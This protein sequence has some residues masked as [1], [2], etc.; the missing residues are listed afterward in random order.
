LK[1]DMT[2]T[3]PTTRCLLLEE[4]NGWLTIWFNQ[5]DS[6]NALSHDLTDELRQV[7][8]IVRASPTC[9]GITL[10]GKGGVFC[11]GG[12]LK[13]FKTNFQGGEQGRKDVVQAS[14]EAGELFD[15][16]NEMPQVVV[17]LVEGAAMAGGLGIVCC[18]D[19]VAVTADARF[20]LTETT[21]G[22]PPAQIAPFV[23][24]RLGLATA[25]RLMLT[26]ARFKGVEAQALGLADFVADDVA[27]LNAIEQDIRSNVM[28]CAP[29][30]N[31]VTKNIVLATEYLER[32]EMLQ[33]A[34]EGFADC[35]LGEEGREGIT[36]FV[37]K[38]KPEWAPE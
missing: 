32:E 35:M 22:I 3:L 15:L 5:P 23:A 19:V 25:R 33:L 7:L 28:R 36:S 26:A 29:G 30:A 12:D 2:L 10:R 9:R 34:A 18:A 8:E 6:R 11:A 21:L 27:A 16:I 20:A 31:A 17:I 38:R 13:S 4:Q 24:R 14:R 37:E 1:E